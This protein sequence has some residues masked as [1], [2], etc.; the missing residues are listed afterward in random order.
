VGGSSINILKTSVLFVLL[1]A[2]H[3]RNVFGSEQSSAVN[4]GYGNFQVRNSYRQADSLNSAL[5][6]LEK[7][8]KASKS[9]EALSVA[10]KLEKLL[11]AGNVPP[12]KAVYPHL[13]VG[14]TYLLNQKETEAENNYRKTLEL[15]KIH[16]VDSIYDKVYYNLGRIYTVM[17]DFIRAET[18]F[19]YSFEYILK[20]Y[21]KNNPR[22]AVEYL[23]RSIS[24]LNLRD[25]EKGLELAN[26][27]LEIARAK[28]PCFIRQRERHSQRYLIIISLSLITKKQWNIMMMDFP[29]TLPTT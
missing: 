24:S 19:T 15:L 28:Q 25:Y 2:G 1:I 16:P 7:L 5:S 8:L 3:G 22:L 18:Y 29:G 21:R 10:K 26:Q 20:L 6:S 23:A 27:G 9:S 14:T 17:G 13:L 12:E 11:L 4:P